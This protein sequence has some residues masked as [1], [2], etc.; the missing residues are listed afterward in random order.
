[1]NGS[2]RLRRLDLTGAAENN[3]TR[4]T[5]EAPSTKRKFVLVSSEE[6]RLQW[7]QA[8]KLVHVGI[9]INGAA[10][11]LESQPILHEKNIN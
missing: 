5:R 6:T 7:L 1:M 11:I 9:A 10:E 4:E 3:K 2:T 8:F